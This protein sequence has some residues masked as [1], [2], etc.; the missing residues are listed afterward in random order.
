M[1]NATREERPAVQSFRPGTFERI[2]PAERISA[3]PLDRACRSCRRWTRNAG[4]CPGTAGDP[5]Y[6]SRGFPPVCHVD[7]A[8]GEKWFKTEARLTLGMPA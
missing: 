7:A 1:T 2:E 6:A 3:A 4:A 8:T 5:W